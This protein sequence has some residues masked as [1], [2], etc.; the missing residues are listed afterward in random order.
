MNMSKAIITF[1][2]YLA[3]GM[4]ELLTCYLF[5]SKTMFTCMWIIAIV[6]LIGFIVTFY[7]ALE[8]EKYR[9]Y[10]VTKDNNYEEIV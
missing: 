8:I 7:N 10:N 5:P 1:I 4:L 9:V 3:I 2:A 6:T